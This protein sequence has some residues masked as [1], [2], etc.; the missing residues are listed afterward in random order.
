MIIT[1][2]INIIMQLITLLEFFVKLKEVISLLP[3]VYVTRCNLALWFLV[4]GKN[5]L[6]VVVNWSNY[7]L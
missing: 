3:S 2:N 6:H 7:I 1:L 5:I 4:N